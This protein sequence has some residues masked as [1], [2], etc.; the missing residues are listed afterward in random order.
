MLSKNILYN[1]LIDYLDVDMYHN[2]DNTNFFYKYFQ[3][4]GCL[5]TILKIF[6]LR[7]GLIISSIF[8]TLTEIHKS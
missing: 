1:H 3:N 6:Y 5:I 4:K 8:T 7:F 2:R